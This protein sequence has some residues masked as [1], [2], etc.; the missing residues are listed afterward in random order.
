M[1]SDF[2]TGYLSLSSPR[3]MLVSQLAGCLMGC[4]AGPLTFYIFWTAFDVGKPGSPYP[5]P[6]ATIFR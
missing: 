1:I 5:A 4:L 2:R 6:Y 3:A